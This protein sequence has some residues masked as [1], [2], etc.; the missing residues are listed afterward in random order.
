MQGT[1]VIFFSTRRPSHAP[2]RKIPLKTGN[3]NHGP[4]RDA[5]LSSYFQMS[6]PSPSH[7]NIGHVPADVMM[8]IITFASLHDEYFVFDVPLTVHRDSF[9]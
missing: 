9:L 4:T 2:E 3:L 8:N 1:I 6:P 7:I 5:P